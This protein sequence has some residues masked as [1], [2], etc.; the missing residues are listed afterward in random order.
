MCIASATINNVLSCG[1]KILRARKR[2]VLL[3]QLI[4]KLTDVIVIFFDFQYF[5]I[6]APVT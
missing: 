3:D 5:L 2:G 6:F 1:A 4:Y